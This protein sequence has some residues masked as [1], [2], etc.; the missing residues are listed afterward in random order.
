MFAESLGPVVKRGGREVGAKRY[1]DEDL[2]M[3][4]D[5]LGV[6]LPGNSVGWET[7][8]SKFNEFAQRNDKPLRDAQSLK[9]MWRKLCTGSPAGG[10]ELSWKQKKA[11]EIRKKID[12][13]FVVIEIG[14]TQSDV[15]EQQS[16]SEECAA[17][18]EKNFES[19]DSSYLFKYLNYFITI[20]RP[21][22][23]ENRYCRN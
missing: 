6:V 21:K 18:C 22:T 10:G 4:F 12:K 14:N 11:R 9:A 19:W 23:K 2:K 3:F 8:T 13:K 16:D 5:I 7:V 20:I 1:D 17:T 15:E